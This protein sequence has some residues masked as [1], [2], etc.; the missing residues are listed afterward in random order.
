V[1]TDLTGSLLNIELPTTSSFNSNTRSNPTPIKLVNNKEKINN[2]HTEILQYGGRYV[3]KRIDAFDN[4]KNTLTIY[5][6]LLDYGTESPTPDN[7]EILTFGLHIPGNY[8]IHQVGNDIVIQLNEY[9]IDF[10]NITLDDIYIF[11]KI[12]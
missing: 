12:K 1:S 2:F 3:R 6:T 11:G 7:F 10:D 9:Y 4:T 8:T 5:N